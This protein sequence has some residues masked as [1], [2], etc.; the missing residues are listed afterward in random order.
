VRNSVLLQCKF[1]TVTL[2]HTGLHCRIDWSCIFR[3]LSGGGL[4]GPEDTARVTALCS[5]KETKGK[6]ISVEMWWWYNVQDRPGWNMWAWHVWDS[7]WMPRKETPWTS[8]EICQHAK[9]Q[10]VSIISIIKRDVTDMDK[11]VHT[12]LA[13]QGSLT[14]S[15]Q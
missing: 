13:T 15:F 5:S 11:L 6:E 12:W 14:G 1:T 3:L 9:I 8:G 10:V 7:L 2:T 4:R